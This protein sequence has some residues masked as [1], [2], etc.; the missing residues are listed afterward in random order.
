MDFCSR[1]ATFPRGVPVHELNEDDYANNINLSSTTGVERTRSKK[2][3]QAL[4]N[5]VTFSSLDLP[6]MAPPDNL[7]N[8]SKGK[9]VATS[10][11]KIKN[12]TDFPLKKQRLLDLRKEK[13]SKPAKVTTFLPK[14]QR[15]KIPFIIKQ[16]A[17][18]GN[19]CFRSILAAQ[20]LNDSSQLELR[21]RCADSVVAEW[22]NYSAYANFSHKPDTNTQSKKPLS[23]GSGPS[24]DLLFKDANDYSSY[25]KR[26]GSWG[27]YLEAEV[28]AKIL[29][30]PLRIWNKHTRRCYDILNYRPGTNTC[31]STIHIIYS[32]GNH[33]Y[34]LIFQG[35]RWKNKQMTLSVIGDRLTLAAR[36]HHIPSS[37]NNVANETLLSITHCSKREN[38]DETQYSLLVGKR[39]HS[40]SI[41]TLPSAYNEQLTSN[42]ASKDKTSILNKR[43]RE[44]C[45]YDK[46][47]ALQGSRILGKPFRQKPVQK[48]TSDNAC[49]TKLK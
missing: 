31:A 43:K 41:R 23:D 28:I 44:K 3:K 34:A 22:K 29:N 19:C 27:S 33:Y 4:R 25:M 16:V 24:L 37:A 14:S 47:K 2:R 18:D 7:I 21:S 10:T 46:S 12:K 49:L 13:F 42:E 39:L 30:I 1:L 6:A 32:N 38:A 45:P 48:S 26:N 5:Q 17:K 11:S 35:S 36:P 9:S 8:R 20:G 15:F 40:E